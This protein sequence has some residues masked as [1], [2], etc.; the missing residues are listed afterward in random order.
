MVLNIK[1]MGNVSPFKSNVNN[2]LSIEDKQI[3]EDKPIIELPIKELW[4]NCSAEEKDRMYL[5]QKKYKLYNFFKVSDP[6]FIYDKIYYKLT[7]KDEK[8]N[9]FQYNDGYN[10][11]ILQFNP[12]SHCLPGGLYFT[13]VENI[14][15]F[16][17]YGIWL[18]EIMVPKDIPVYYDSQ[19][20]YQKYKAPILILGKK[21]SIYSMEAFNLLFGTSDANNKYIVPKLAVNKEISAGIKLFELLSTNQINFSTIHQYLQTIIINSIDNDNQ[22]MLTYLTLNHTTYIDAI[23]STMLYDWLNG[24]TPERQKIYLA[25]FVD[26]YIPMIINKYQQEYFSIVSS[27]S[28]NQ[29]VF[30]SDIITDNTHLETFN[31]ILF[32]SKSVISGSCVLKEKTHDDFKINDIDIYC[33]VDDNYELKTIRGTVKPTCQIELFLKNV[34]HARKQNSYETPYH[35]MKGIA[36]IV[37]YVYNKITFQ[38]II[39]NVDPV[40][41]INNQFDFDF[42]KVMYDGKTIFTK[43]NDSI[44]DKKIGSIT[45]SYIQKSFYTDDGQLIPHTQLSAINKYRITKTIERSIKYTKRGFQ[46]KNIDT[47][48]NY[49]RQ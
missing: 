36:R 16:Q 9:G 14:S 31:K 24:K 38:L 45:N 48:L 28:G 25:Y 12:Q 32:V 3:I 17:T 27:K 13:S 2:N 11:D 41:F 37:S 21:I 10:Y 26:T 8:H 4:K 34:L 6:T 43:E 39:L 15:Q 22:S 1:Y 7:N 44:F 40:E 33:P 19:P 18:R 49:L 5:Y 46:I 29:N 20:N 23:I 30:L 35:S 47:Y 42:C